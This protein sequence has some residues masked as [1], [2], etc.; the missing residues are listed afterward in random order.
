MNKL[1]RDGKVAVLYSRGFGAGWYTWNTDHPECLYDPE[2]VKIVLGEAEGSI[3]EIACKNYGD[4]FYS[5][6]S[7]GLY[8]EWIPIGTRFQIL[9]YDGAEDLIVEGTDDDDWLVAEEE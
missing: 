4:G 8:V 1:I 2:I 6:G 5:G 3:N 7:H 9:E